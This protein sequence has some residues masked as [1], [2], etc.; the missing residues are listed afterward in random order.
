MEIDF[1]SY[2]QSIHE[3]DEFGICDDCNQT[4]VYICTDKRDSR[5]ADVTNKNKVESEF[6]P[7]DNNIPA[8]KR[9][10]PEENDR[11]CDAILYTEKSLIFVELKNQSRDWFNNACEQ[12]AA[13]ITLFKENHPERFQGYQIRRAYVCNKQHP[14]YNPSFTN[15]IRAFHSENGTAL[16]SQ[17]DIQITK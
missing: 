11:R 5:I 3:C 10:H 8:P 12:L 9:E 14:L 4:P 16:Y 6:I 7:V 1:Y 15:R 2:S 17:T 13:T